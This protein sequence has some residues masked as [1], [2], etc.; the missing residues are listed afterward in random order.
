[1]GG[2][3][4]IIGTG[5]HGR[6][7]LDVVEALVAAGES[8]RVLGFLDDSP[9]SHGTT[10]RGLPVLGGVDWL[11]S[12]PRGSLP[13]AFLGIGAAAIRWRLAERL[14]AMGVRSPS[15][16][17]PRAAITPHVDIEEGVMLAAGSVITSSVRIGAFSFLNV[18]AS[19]SHDC[20]VGRCCSIQMGARL[21]G[22]VMIG[23]GVEI[24]VGAV[25]RQ[26]IEIGEW[27]TIGAGAAVVSAIPG[28]VVAVGVPAR[29]T[30]IR[31]PG[32]QHA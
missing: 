26:N 19:V 2:D 28:N 27:T 24:G 21:S 4:V 22:T 15:L 1:M 14:A 23:N 7:A 29:I 9:D 17:H 6:E 12:R 5:G 10:V 30:E 16:V 32:W 18:G 3:L 25:V 13:Q 31:E 11:A 20:I 8:W